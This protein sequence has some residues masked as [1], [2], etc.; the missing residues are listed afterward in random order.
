MAKAAAEP[1]WTLL[2]EATARVE[3][4]Y[5]SRELAERKLRQRLLAGKLRWR[6]DCLEGLKQ[7][8]DPGS[9]DPEFWLYPG[10]A[11]P[12]FWTDLDPVDIDGVVGFTKPSMVITWD[13]SCAQRHGY[14]FYRIEV[15]EDDLIQ[16]MPAGDAEG[17]EAGAKAWITAEA[18]RMKTAGEIPSGIIKTKFAQLLE[19]QIKAAARRGEVTKPVGYR[20]IVNKLEDWGLWPISSI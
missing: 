6:S 2:S 14:V 8:W 12:E 9:G 17:D 19:G 16:L 11:D 1:K 4:F 5:Q 10:S 3:N 20:H 18:K 7:S 15:A 13:Q